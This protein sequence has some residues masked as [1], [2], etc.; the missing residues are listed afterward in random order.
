[1]KVMNVFDVEWSHS[2]SWKESYLECGVRDMNLQH[3]AQR[4]PDNVRWVHRQENFDAD[5][6]NTG[7][8]LFTDKMLRPEWRSQYLS[9]KSPCKVAAVL[10]SFG[11]T[12]QIYTYITELEDCFDFIF[13]YNESLLS[14]DP[15]KYKFI[16]GGWVCLEREAYELTESVEKS[17]MISMIYSE[18]SCNGPTTP[19]DE[20][21][22]RHQVAKRFGDRIDL[23]GSGSPMG[24]ELMKS[25]TLTDYRFSV[26]I[27][28]T[29]T[30][31]DTYYSEK[32]LD[33]FVTR[34]V[35]IYR[36]TSE[37]VNFFDKDGIILW[38]ELDELEDVLDNLSV[39]RYE[40]MKPHMENNYH[41]AKKYTS[42]DDTFCELTQRC[43]LN[44]EYNTKEF[45]K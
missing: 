10:E 14:R 35:P 5:G 7:I 29:K 2:T 33:C 19:A 41:L 6:D 39:E 45:F 25:R 11:V 13:T 3:L 12:P 18:K 31:V 9:V 34:N 23:F 4:P 38:T 28:N 20:R 8:T 42:P 21:H 27:E 26:V 1:M 32:I 22:V 36:G 30:S 24:E 17:K 15:K 40:K 16:P 44:N 43:Q 37:I